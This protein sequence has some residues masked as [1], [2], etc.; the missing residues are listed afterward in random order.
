MPRLTDFD[1]RWID[2]GDRKGLGFTMCCAGAGPQHGPTC[3]HRIPVLFAN[4]LDG[5][6]PYEGNSYDLQE[7]LGDGEHSPLYRGCGKFRWKRDPLTMTFADLSLTPSV[8][9]HECGHFTITAGGW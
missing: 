6:P 8:N 3:G 2:L 4:P 5:G 1:P 7:A 9:S